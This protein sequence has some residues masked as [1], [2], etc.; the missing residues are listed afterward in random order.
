MESGGD[1]ISS[2]DVVLKQRGSKDSSAVVVIS[3]AKAMAMGR[4]STCGSCERYPESMIERE[5]E[6]WWTGTQIASRID[7]SYFS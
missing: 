7:L 6:L 3:E 2:L 1:S 4:I 5:E